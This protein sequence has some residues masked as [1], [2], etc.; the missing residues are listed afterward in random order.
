MKIKY[1]SLLGAALLPVMTGCASTP[2]ALSSVGPEPGRTAGS[3]TSGRLQVFT[4]TQQSTA[5]GD[6][7]PG[8]YF[9]PHT[10]YDLNN[11]A[12][13]HLKFVANH[14]SDM[15]E[16]PDVVK[17]PAGHY[18]IVAESSC[19]GSV[20]VPVVIENGKTTVVHLD[21]NWWPPRHTPLNQVVFLP[22]GEGV[23]WSGAIATS[24]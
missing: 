15:D 6:I 22:D 9:Y 2:L 21:R 13:T 18:T 24:P 11:A 7:G 20:T 16:S 17:L 4:A 8:S 14:M 10:G 19:C 12:G 5:I 1:I 3:G 23:G